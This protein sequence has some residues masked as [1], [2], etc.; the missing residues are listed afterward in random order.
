[1][2]IIASTLGL[3]LPRH[4][5]IAKWVVEYRKILQ[6][7]PIKEGTLKERMRYVNCLVDG[8]GRDRRLCVVRPSDISRLIH[9]MHQRSPNSSRR[10]LHEARS[11]FDAAIAEG[12]LDRNPATPIRPLPAPVQRKRL[13]LQ[14][15]RQAYEWSRLP[16]CPSHWAQH[17][18][19]LALITGQ[20]RADLQKMRF[21]D[22]RNG[23]LYIE[24]Q[25]TG[26]RIALPIALRLDV[27][28][29]TLADAI[30]G[31]RAYAPPGPTL[32]RKTTGEAPCV[33]SLSAVFRDAY[34]AIYGRE[35]PKDGT[36]PSLHEC[37]SLSER[38]YRTQG[39]DTQTLLGH[40]N[41][42][43]TDVYNDD[44]GLSR[45]EWKILSLPD[46]LSPHEP[47]PC[48]NPP[49]HN[50]IEEARLDCTIAERGQEALG[51]DH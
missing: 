38:L 40:A 16:T 3:F 6:A 28:G 43:M 9:D 48:G 14:E 19:L 50:Q 1:M 21:D 45:G 39:I 33:A 42:A 12:W 25:K 13:T 49:Q 32:L 46:T 5:T 18:L 23:M 26:S 27:V 51:L 2:N 4:R 47:R 34:V 31:C 7:M 22:V 20:R 29:L 24:Q 37:R 30:E 44:R 15:W 17:M 41:S 8:L 11:I 35:W 10:M 36:P